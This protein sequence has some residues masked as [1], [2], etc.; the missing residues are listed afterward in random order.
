MS[1]VRMVPTV[2]DAELKRT[3]IPVTALTKAS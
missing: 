3:N 2:V 1:L